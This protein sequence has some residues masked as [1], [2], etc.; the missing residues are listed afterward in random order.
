[1]PSKTACFLLLLS[2]SIAGGPAAATQPPSEVW[3]LG[4]LY[5]DIAAWE[6]AFSATAQHIDTLGDCR[7]RLGAGPRQLRLLPWRQGR[8]LLQRLHLLPKRHRVQ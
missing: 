7:G 1:M 8:L 3:D 4:D 6:T 2:L 5:P